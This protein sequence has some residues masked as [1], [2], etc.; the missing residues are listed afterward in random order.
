M[1][2]K[3]LYRSRRNKMVAG[4]AGGIGKYLDV[5]PV[6][7]RVLFI[8]LTFAGGSGAILYLILMSIMP[9]DPLPLEVPGGRTHESHD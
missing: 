8:F 9:I 7:F 6:I 1:A 5:D 4:V 2:I 3:K